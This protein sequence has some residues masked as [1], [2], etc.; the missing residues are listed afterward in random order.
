MCGLTWAIAVC[1]W[2]WAIAACL[3]PLRAKATILATAVH[4]GL[5]PFGQG[6]PATPCV[7]WLELLQRL[8][9]QQG[10]SD[11]LSHSWLPASTPG[12]AGATGYAVCGLAS[13]ITAPL[14]PLG[15]KRPSWPR[16]LP[17]SPPLAGATGYAV[18]VWN[19]A[20]VLV[21]AICQC[22][23][24]WAGATGYAVCGWNWA[25]E[26]SYG[27]SP[28]PPPVGGSDRLC[29]VWLKLSYCV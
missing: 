21:T 26:F 28:V 22:L 25:I 15:R 19:C 17:A 3:S 5:P 16:L 24:C 18:C 13:A 7:V 6:R 23:P 27:C 29:C 14:S 8:F 11:C 2:N 4:Q 12:W 10:E 20:I 1:G 9:P